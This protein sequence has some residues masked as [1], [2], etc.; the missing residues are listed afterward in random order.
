M[1]R[2]H[3]YRRQF[4]LVLL[5]GLVMTGT[6]IAHAHMAQVVP[7]SQ[8]LLITASR[9]LQSPDAMSVTGQNFTPG[10]AVYVVL[11]DRLGMEQ[12]EPHWVTATEPVYGANGSQDPATGF[13]QG[14]TIDELFGTFATVYRVNGS[15]DPASGYV[16]GGA[17][18]SLVGRVCGTSVMIRAYDAQSGAWSNV[19][20]VDPGC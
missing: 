15:Q 17:D 7:D 1:N 20:D 3:H 12:Y 6:S 4:A 19:L 11:Y 14:G 2:L 5:L 8:P 9:S 18:F 16:V 10:G 13:R